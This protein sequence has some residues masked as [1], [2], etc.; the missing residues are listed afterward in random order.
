MSKEIRFNAF[1]M[2]CVGHMAPG[3]WRH[4]RDCSNRYIDLNYWT[5]LARLL[6]RGKF[7][8]LFLAD[9]LGPYD[10]YQGRADA[11]IYSGIQIPVNDPLLLVSGMAAVTEHLGFGV[12]CALTYEHPYPFARRASTLDHLTKGR[13]GWN[14][15]SGYLDSAARNFGLDQQTQHDDRYAFAEEYMQVCY[16]LWERSWDHDAVRRDRKG[17]MFAD[18][19]KVHGIKHSGEYFKVPGFNLSEPSPQRTPVLYQAGASRRGK[20]FAAK[21]AECVF[22]SAPTAP[23]VKK[24]VQDLRGQAAELGRGQ[25]LIFAMFTII[26]APGEA[27]AAEKLHEYRSYIDYEGALALMSG[28]TGVDLSAY[29]LDEELRPTKTN[30]NQSALESFT[31]GEPDRRW[32][33]REIAE[34]VGLG[35]RGPV[36]VGSPTQVADLL[37]QWIEETDV[38]GFNLA[39]A[40]MPETYE[41]I[42]DLLVPE[43]Q[44][45]GVYKKEYRPGSLREKLFGQGPFLP[46]TH[47]GRRALG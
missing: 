29:D 40:V 10:V 35:G 24:Y 31:V 37:Q 5:G 44:H 9:V 17:G 36:V 42:I 46:E 30:A 34:F 21:H 32:K 41:N 6:E 43:L 38:D 7:D 22:V 16:K 11:A 3:L 33:I 26:V 4:P 18:P 15:V 28:W 27:E 1:A 47:P 19:A 20:D 25:I 8:G 14:I 2:N 23:I 39:Y 45:R 13:F 12:T